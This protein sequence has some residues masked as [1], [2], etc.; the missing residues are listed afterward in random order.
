LLDSGKPGEALPKLTDLAQEATDADGVEVDYQLALALAD[1]HNAPG[2]REL[3]EKVLWRDP[4]VVDPTDLVLKWLDMVHRG[5]DS[6]RA[7][8]L[9]QKLQAARPEDL[10]PVKLLIDIAEALGDK[11]ESI[12]WWQYLV[13][14]QPNDFRHKA[15]LAARLMNA[16][17]DAQ[18]RTLLDEVEGNAA[19][20][21]DPDV[22][23]QF[24]RAWA[25]RDPIK[26]RGYLIEARTYRPTAAVHM[27]LGQIDA[28]RNK[29]DTALE[30]F[31]EA[32]KLEPGLSDA[33]IQIAKIE[34]A[35]GN[36]KKAQQELQTLVDEKPDD[37]TLR[38]LLGDTWRDLE[39]PK[40]AIKAYQQAAELP[41]A[42]VGELYL[43]IGR[44]QLQDL[45]QVGPAVKSLK[46]AVAA[47]PKLAE[48]YYM[49][50]YALKDL[51]KQKEARQ[52]LES[53]IQVA[54]ADDVTDDLKN[55]LRDLGGDV[56]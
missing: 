23:Y 56:P 7:L 9:A 12:K 31:Q 28:K 46:K 13:K 35:N 20:K 26:A 44:M 48:A 50:G 8:G 42:R 37:P 36:L 55:D 17:R 51:G 53:F 39:R 47:D 11:D 30:S 40:D 49:L 34:L 21:K 22:L 6:A 18:A 54:P 32:I 41:G 27:L 10:R 25:E 29:T 4:T 38:E 1:R 19:A 52:A 5:G 16:S 2:A 15:A 24:A 14:L 33:H 43:K 45:S 3:L